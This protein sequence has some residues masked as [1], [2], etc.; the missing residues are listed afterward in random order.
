MF[1]VWKNVLAELE[2]KVSSEKFNTYLDKTS[3]ISINDSRVVIGVPNVF[4]QTNI[5]KNF[6]KDIKEALKDN[7]VDFT[8]VEYEIVSSSKKIR[9]PREV[10][11]REDNVE[12]VSQIATSSIPQSRTYQ[13]TGLKA[14]FTFDNFVVGSNNDLAVATAKLVVAK[15]GINKNPFFVYGKSGLGKTH[16]VQA[17]GNAIIKNNPKAKVLYIPI[18]HFYSDFIDSVKAN[19]TDAFRKKY[20]NL[21]VLIV[22]DF[23]LIVGKEKSQEEFF[24]LFNDMYLSNRQVIIT[25][26]RLPSELKTVD[27]RL[28]SRITMTGPYD[29][30]YPSFED[31]CA[32][33]TAKAEFAGVDIER[34]AIE[35]IAE[36]VKTNVRDLNAEYEKLIAYSDLRGMTPLEVI[37][38][39]FTSTSSSFAHKKRTTPKKIITKVAKYYGM[40]V[41][42]MLSKSRVANIKNARQVA[43]YLMQNELG[44]S[45]TKTATELGMKDHTTVMN[46]VK[47]VTQDLKMNFKLRDDLDKLREEIYA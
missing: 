30:Q 36:N 43:M 10:L 41:E 46:G 13:N 2:H 34:E 32:I 28:A 38:S 39:G 25:S 8:S 47:R 6:D 26:D 14:D 27:E 18:N 4:M 35:Y 16:L 23:Q 29:I 31:R 15:P 3:L 11:P 33:L 17:I 5:K 19:K 42:T 20:E 40:S 45:T 12:P 37:K 24:N 1:D 22:D 44:L 21:D 9:R 7:G